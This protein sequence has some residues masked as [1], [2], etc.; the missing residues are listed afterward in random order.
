MLANYI[1]S[2][3][4]PSDQTLDFPLRPRGLGE[5]AGQEGIKERLE[6]MIQ[7]AKERGEPLNHCLFS[8]PPGLGKTTLAHILA[9]SMGTQLIVTSGPVLEKPGDLAGLLTSLKEGDLF[10]IDEIHR[11]NKQVEEYLYCAMEDFVIDLVI[12]SGPSARSIQ[13]KLNKFTLVGA[14]TRSGLLSAPLRSR[15]PFNCRLDYYSSEVLKEI[16]LR[17]S[18]IFKVDL[19]SSAAFEIARRSRGTPRIANNLLRWVRDYAQV[20]AANRISEKTAIEAL[21]LLAVDD[22]GL[23]EMDKRILSIIIDYHD[24]GPVGI[25][26]IAA[27]VGE[28]PDTIEDVYE[29]YLIMQGFLER[30]SRGRKATSHAYAHLKNE[31]KKG[32]V[33]AK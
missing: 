17:T 3:F 19:E 12:D 21:E 28:E 6:V 1:E 2:S 32:R 16:L 29:P 14:T 5:F 30:T 7:A 10:F 23:D 33:Y 26:T 31:R 27:A 13:L 4:T 20:R 22:R 8:G 24:G 25:N 18:V 11:L 9:K 15:F